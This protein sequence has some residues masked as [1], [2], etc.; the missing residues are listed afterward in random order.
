MLLRNV[1]RSLL[2]FVCRRLPIYAGTGR[3]A[4]S[5]LFEAVAASSQFVRAKQ[6]DGTVVLVDPQ[7]TLGRTILYFG[8]QDPKV[9]WVYRKLLRPGD[10]LIDVGAN[11]GALAISAARIVG[12]QGEVFAFEPQIELAKLIDRSATE[13]GLSNLTVLPVALSDH[14][15]TAE[16][17]VP[18]CS[19]G[20]ASLEHDYSLSDTRT[21]LSVTLVASDR[22]LT[23][24]IGERPVRLVKIDVE[25]H[26]AAVVRGA[27]SWIVQKLPDY[28][29]FEVSFGKD[30]W[31][32]DEAKIL[33]DIGYSF[34]GLPH[35]V[36]PMRLARLDFGQALKDDLR[37]VLAVRPGLPIEPA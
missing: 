29:L 2:Q 9:S 22:C 26:E 4:N 7:D 15:G 20:Y 34:L 17:V 27:R 11:V 37:D 33:N 16:L 12:P 13:N 32:R 1:L 21:R 23:K 28:I 6:R 31:L 35:V 25:G 19:S 24:A 10:T 5:A 36:W 3:I 14:D 8:E 30:L 18:L